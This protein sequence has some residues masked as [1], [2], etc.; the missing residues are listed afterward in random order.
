MHWDG[1]TPWRE[2]GLFATLFEARTAE[3]NYEATTQ[4]FTANKY[5]A[6]GLE[7]E[8]GYKLGDFKLTAGTTFTK[9]KISASSDASTVGNRPRRQAEFVYQL[10]PS[11]AIGP[12]EVGA[13]IIGTG[14][15]WGDDAN[16][17][18]QPGFTVLNAFVNYQ[19][20]DRLGVSVSANN[21]TNTIGYTEVEGDGHAARSINGRTIKASVKYSF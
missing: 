21:L 12:V 2:P 19:V 7:L 15:S 10:A 6:H 5:K 8:M 17:I 18:T 3:S 16:T 1:A 20:N 14:K 11:Y 4:T 13:A 9:A